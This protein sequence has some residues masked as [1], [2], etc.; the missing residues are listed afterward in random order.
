MALLAIL[1]VLTAARIGT[2]RLGS[3]WRLWPVSIGLAAA[4]FLYVLP[5]YVATFDILTGVLTSI[6]SVGFEPATQFAETS[7]SLVYLSMWYLPDGVW[8]L[9]FGLGSDTQGSDI[10]YVKILHMGG[11]VLLACIVLF[12]L[13]LRNACTVALRASM[14]LQ[15]MRERVESR[16]LLFI[17]A[18]FLVVLI[19]SNLKNLY[20]L[21]RGYHE[22]FVV[23][24]FS[25]LGF[26]DYFRSRIMSVVNSDVDGSR[27][28]SS[29]VC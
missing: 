13:Y 7:L 24:S 9:L 26:Q 22:L 28:T 6:R 16:L 18:L 2:V 4:F 23:L 21:T 14:S 10:G 25:A 12:I 5:L 29:V 20:F 19:L 3:I 8:H 17:I 15:T 11:L 27:R 1:F